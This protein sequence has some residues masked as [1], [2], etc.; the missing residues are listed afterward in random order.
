MANTGTETDDD[1]IEDDERVLHVRF[2]RG[3][4]ERIEET[5]RALD[6]GDTPEPYFEVT[7]YRIEDLNLVTRPTNLQLLR[8]I[9]GEN[10]GSIRETARLAD[11]GVRQVHRNLEELEALGMIELVSHGPGKPTEPQVWYETIEVDLPLTTLDDSTSEAN[12]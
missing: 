7:F 2:R 5:F 9:A 11:R 4:D 3:D 10:P 1:G 12:V 6:R 8:T